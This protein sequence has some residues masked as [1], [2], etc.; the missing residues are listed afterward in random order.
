MATSKETAAFVL[1]HLGHP[2]RFTLRSMFGEY[3][4]YAD[5]KTVAFIYQGQLYARVAPGSEELARTCE[6]VPMWPGS[7][8]R[9]LVT[10]EELVGNRRLPEI[11]LQMAEHLPLPHSQR[12]K[13]KNSQRK[14]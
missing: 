4:V 9:Y 6:K 11:L 5:G 2:G 7:R 10:E 1:R 8:Q 14:P 12:R 3:A 13:A